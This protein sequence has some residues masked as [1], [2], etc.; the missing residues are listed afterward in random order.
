MLVVSSDALN[1]SPLVVLA[2]PGTKATN[3]P[4]DY[5]VNVR[6]SPAESGLP[7]E[8]VFLCYQVRALDHSRFQDP[9]NGQYLTAAGRLSPAK[10]QEIE[11]ALRT[12]LEL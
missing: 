4:A 8:T 9:A 10:M 5:S 7:L 1:S 12:V 11:A 3:L 6:V 2:V